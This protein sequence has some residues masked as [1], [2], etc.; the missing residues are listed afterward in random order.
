[1][2]SILSCGCL[3]FFFFLFFSFG[4][5]G[6]RKIYLL[7][8][9]S[10]KLSMEFICAI[11]VTG[12]FL[13]T[14]VSHRPL[15]L[16]NRSGDAGKY[17]L[18]A[19]CSYRKWPQGGSTS[20]YQLWNNQSFRNCW[21]PG[22][23]IREGCGWANTQGFKYHYFFPLKLYPSFPDSWLPGALLPAKV[24]RR[25]HTQEG[26]LSWGPSARALDTWRLYPGPQGQRVR[27]PS[28]GCTRDSGPTQRKPDSTGLRGVS[29]QGTLPGCTG[30]TQVQLWDSSLL[31]FQG[32]DS[33]PS[34]GGW[35]D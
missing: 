9:V 22:L 7:Q 6:V 10:W 15:G 32:S 14:V 8:L 29:M 27:P 3:C 25:L 21:L 30:P 17:R 34:Q 11:P 12:P 5:N 24:P 18:L 4:L 16:V 19:S 2:L 31:R 23:C 1:M 28:L 20:S 26:A 13:R 33:I 35:R